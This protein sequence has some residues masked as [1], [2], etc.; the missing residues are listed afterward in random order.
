MSTF[1]KIMRRVGDLDDEFYDDERQ[2]DVWNEASAVGMQLFVWVSLV[3][4]AILPWVAG[5]TGSWIALG[6][7]VVYLSIAFSVVGYA[8]S[9]GLD[10]YTQQNLRRPRIFLATVLYLVGAFAAIGSLVLGQVDG[11]PP[12]ALG[13]VIGGI[14]GFIAAAMGLTAKRRADRDRERRQEDRE[15][16]ELDGE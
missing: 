2:R 11:N 7:L 4:A 9:R 16:L 15:R 6:L 10:M 12:F 1:T 13:M 8:R 5:R 14:G 3:A